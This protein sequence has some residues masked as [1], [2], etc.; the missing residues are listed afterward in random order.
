MDITGFIEQK[1]AVRLIVIPGGDAR[2][3]NF[4]VVLSVG[5]LERCAQKGDWLRREIACALNL[6]KNILPVLL[7]GFKFPQELPADIR[8][9]PRR[10]ST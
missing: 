5:A 9:L 6:N 10:T 7:P 3:S 1:V 8:D 2:V 4:L